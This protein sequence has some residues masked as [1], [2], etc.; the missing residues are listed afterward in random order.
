MTTRMV[1]A[2]DFPRQPISVIKPKLPERLTAA[3]GPSVAF[4]VVV[5]EIDWFPAPVSAVCRETGL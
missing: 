4:F 5:A 1:L 2:T 3:A